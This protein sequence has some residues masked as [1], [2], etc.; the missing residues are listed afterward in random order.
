MCNSNLIILKAILLTT[1]CLSVIICFLATTGV[2]FDLEGTKSQ[3][4][5]LSR[6]HNE[7]ETERQKSLVNMDITKTV[8]SSVTSQIILG[9]AIVSVAKKQATLV[10]V[11]SFLLAAL[12]FYSAFG[13]TDFRS[14]KYV[15]LQFELLVVGFTVTYAWMCHKQR[16]GVIFA[17]VTQQEDMEQENL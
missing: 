3:I 1:F 9:L 17:E 13:V 11:S 10:L 15:L 7:T 14:W 12:A 16:S 8:I 2:L 6:Y 4:D 5:R